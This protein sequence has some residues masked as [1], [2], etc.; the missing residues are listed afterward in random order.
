MQKKLQ[1]QMGTSKIILSQNI[2]TIF[3]PK[4]LLRVQKYLKIVQKIHS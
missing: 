1:K 4:N 2:A 3:H